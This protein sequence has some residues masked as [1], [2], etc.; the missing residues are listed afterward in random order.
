MATPA[1]VEAFTREIFPYAIE[2]QLTYG[3]PWE[4]TMAQANLESAYGTKMAC[5]N[6]FYGHKAVGK[7]PYCMTWTEEYIGGKKVTVKEPF[8]IY[9]S[10]KAG[11]MAKGVFFKE[12]ARYAPAFKYTDA[13]RFAREIAKAGYAT[14]PDYYQILLA[15]INTVRGLV[16]KYG[17]GAKPTKKPDSTKS[18]PGNLVDM[19]FVLLGLGLVGYG[20]YKAYRYFKGKR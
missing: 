14:A 5:A 16:K 20:S 18:Q 15:N 19:G 12:N 8:R 4:V 17:L 1:Q 3:V 11:F 6:N 13:E 7:Q 10:R 2:T 9:P